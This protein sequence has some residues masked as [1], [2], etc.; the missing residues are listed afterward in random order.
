MSPDNLDLEEYTVYLLS[1]FC[2][3]A[4]SIT[5]G[6]DDAGTV[7][8]AYEYM[9]SLSQAD[10]MRIIA[11][12]LCLVWSGYAGIVNDPEFDLLF[13]IANGRE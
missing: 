13:R 12:L 8:I 5:Q 9:K 10:M 6:S 3:G 4:L 1:L 7:D 2:K 11:D